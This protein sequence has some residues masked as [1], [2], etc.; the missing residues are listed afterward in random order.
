MPE[1]LQLPKFIEISGQLVLLRSFTFENIT[2]EY[3]G[4][5]NDPLVV[6]YSNQR[7][8][9]H[10]ISTCE[11][12]LSSFDGS[13]HRFLSI[14]DLITKKPIGTATVY[15]ARHHATADAGIMIGHHEFRGKGYGQDAWN[16]LI[17]WLL[18]AGGLRKVTAGALACNYPM[19]QLMKRSGMHLEAVRCRQEI[20][21]YHEEDLVLYAKF[22]P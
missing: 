18:G 16:A 17:Y 12:Y 8:I 6:R 21:E 22:R 7:F 14:C 15:V 3:I 10:N 4:W 19:V 13:D 11:H 20:V 5:L 9:T 1:T 2:D